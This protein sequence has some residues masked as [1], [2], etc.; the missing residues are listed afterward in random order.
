MIRA[1]SQQGAKALVLSV[2]IYESN[3]IR[4]I[5]IEGETLGKVTLLDNTPSTYDS[6]DKLVEDFQKNYPTFA[7]L[8]KI[9]QA[10]IVQNKTEYLP[11]AWKPK[12]KKGKSFNKLIFFFDWMNSLSHWFIQ[13]FFFLW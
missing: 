13:R 5:K 11:F 8:G 6:L 9:H 10:Q 1:S 7:P 2:L 3:Q 12:K 4:H